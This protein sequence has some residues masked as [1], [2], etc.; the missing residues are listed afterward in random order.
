MQAAGSLVV[1]MRVAIWLLI[2]LLDNTTNAQLK[3]T[4]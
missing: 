3:R 2:L 4:L 1:H